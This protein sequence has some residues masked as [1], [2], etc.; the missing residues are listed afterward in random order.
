MLCL[1]TSNNRSPH[2]HFISQLKGYGISSGEQSFLPRIKC[3][4]ETPRHLYPEGLGLKQMKATI[5]WNSRIFQQAPWGEKIPGGLTQL[6]PVGF[7]VSDY[8]ASSK[9]ACFLIRAGGHSS[10]C[11]AS[12]FINSVIVLPKDSNHFCKMPSHPQDSPISPWAAL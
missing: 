3:Y 9:L 12:R 11:R 8:M 5:H 1:R 10:M 6:H 2:Q 7:R 4:P